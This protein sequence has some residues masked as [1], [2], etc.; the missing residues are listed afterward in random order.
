MGVLTQSCFAGNRT[1]ISHGG[2]NDWGI[3]TDG[4]LST[5]SITPA[6]EFCVAPALDGAKALAGLSQSQHLAQDG[7]S[8]RNCA[9]L[10]SHDQFCPRSE[11]KQ[12]DIKHC[13]SLWFQ[14]NPEQV[15]ST[16]GEMVATLCESSEDVH[17]HVS[18]LS[19]GEFAETFCILPELPLP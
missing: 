5:T 3:D 4:Q 18:G 2:V 12:L 7:F 19:G 6:P 13:H 14:V 17:A 9:R 16:A 10:L 11:L 1:V 15:P 8:Q